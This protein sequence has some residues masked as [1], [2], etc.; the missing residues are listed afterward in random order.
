[1]A[2]LLDVWRFEIKYGM[3]QLEALSLIPKVAFILPADKNNKGNEG[4]MIRSLYFDSMYDKDYQAKEDGLEEHKKIRIRI[5]E[6]GSNVAKLELKEKT[7]KWQR[8]RSLTIT[9]D[10]AERLISMDYSP[11][12]EFSDPLAVWLYNTMTLDMYRPR[13]IVQY[14]RTAFMLNANDIRITFDSCIEAS[15]SNF[16]LFSDNIALYPAADPC[17]VVLEVK[18]NG[19]ILSYISNTV[20]EANKSPISFSKYYMSRKYSRNPEV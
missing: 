3:T 4:Y 19:F 11:L 5:Y 18:Y 14:N 2:D 16:D 1:M 20:S 9:R 17:V 8:K 10:A 7:G 13:C 12:L 6:S 15:E